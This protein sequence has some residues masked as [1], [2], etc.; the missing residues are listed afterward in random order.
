MKSSKSVK[1]P[2]D[3]S[4]APWEFDTVDVG[5]LREQAVGTNHRWDCAMQKNKTTSTKITATTTTTTTTTTRKTRKTRI[6]WP[7]Q[8][9]LCFEYSRQYYNDPVV[10]LHPPPSRTTILS[11]GFCNSVFNLISAPLHFMGRNAANP[12]VFRLRFPN[13]NYESP[14][15]EQLVSRIFKAG[16]QRP[17]GCSGPWRWNLYLWWASLLKIQEA[18]TKPPRLFS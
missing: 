3:F 8:I 13:T 17:R 1:I 6:Q 2:S 15:G 16:R 4:V 12:A 18:K 9:L 11:T 14:L 5:H 10:V 7:R